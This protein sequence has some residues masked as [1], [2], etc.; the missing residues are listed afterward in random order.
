MNKK[1]SLGSACFFM[2]IIA[3]ITF[4]IT[5]T[6]SLNRFNGIVLNVKER[7]EMYKKLSEIER[8]ARQSYAGT[9]DENVLLESISS[10]FIKGLSD[11]HSN[12]I[13]KDA[14]EQI[15]LKQSGN[16]VSIGITVQKDVSGYFIVTSVLQDSPAMKAGILVDDILIKID[17]KDLQNTTLLVANDMLNGRPGSNISVT[18]RRNS[19]DATK[20][21][22]RKEVSVN[23]VESKLIDTVGYLKINELNDKTFGQLKKS[24]DD[25]ISQGTTGL[26][27]DVRNNADNDFDAVIRILNMLLPY[28]ETATKIDNKGNKSPMSISDEYNIGLPM[29]VLINGKTSGA[30]EYFASAM[31]DFKSAS[32][33][34]VNSAGKNSIQ[35]LFPLTDG[36]AIYITTGHFLP[37]IQPDINGIGIKPEYEVKLTLEQELNLYLLDENNDPQLIKALNVI[38]SKLDN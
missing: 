18:Y 15:L 9:I 19:V 26:I 3:A 28:G 37:I 14:Y 30:S 31:Q 23:F 34:G 11:K 29:A 7:E 12:Y 33:V 24:I 2:I 10:G 32:I 38:N 36:S 27:F 25:L 17:D 13:S 8:T 35:E 1:I 6:S 21:M 4:S 20:S 16:R 5:M 22:Q